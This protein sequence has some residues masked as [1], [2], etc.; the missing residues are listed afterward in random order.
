VVPVD[1]GG[2]GHEAGALLAVLLDVLRGAREDQ[3][4]LQIGKSVALR[5]VDRPTVGEIPRVDVIGAEVLKGAEVSS[6]G[7]EVVVRRREGRS[8]ED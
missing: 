2:L 5:V 8:F 4:D 3:V 1:L 6:D 7:A